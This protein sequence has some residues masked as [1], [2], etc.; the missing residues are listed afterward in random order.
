MA[1]APQHPAAYTLQPDDFDPAFLAALAAGTDEGW[2]GL[3]RELVPGVYATRILTPAWCHQLAEEVASIEAWC[4]EHDVELQ[5]P[6][7][8]NEYGLILDE[9]GFRPALGELLT[10][11]LRPLAARL[12]PDIGGATLDGHHGF[13]VDYA[14][15]RDE[16]L[17][18]HVD[19][20]EV[21]LN[22]CLGERFE[23]SELYFRGARCERHRQTP[24]GP[25]EDLELDH[26]PGVAIL[27]AGKQRHGVF[28]IRRGRRRNLI[29][30]CSSSEYRASLPQP[31][32]CPA[33][34]GARRPR[35]DA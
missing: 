2:R 25:G 1:Y 33:W 22:V 18:F 4:D 12:Y 11:Y 8:M 15:G 17:G 10:R 21:T 32:E 27:H 14:L 7:S 9:V 13:V 31:P 26:E 3:V 35:A 16:D 24:C 34:C 19:D 20:S 6:N 28:P 23:G 29:V 30:W 5:R